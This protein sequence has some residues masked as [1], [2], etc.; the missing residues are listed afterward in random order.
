[1]NSCSHI[2]EGETEAGVKS[3]ASDRVSEKPWHKESL[4]LDPEEE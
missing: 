1:M 2:I 4:G 3:L